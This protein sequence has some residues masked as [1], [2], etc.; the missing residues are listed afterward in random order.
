M[1]KKT[2]ICLL[3]TISIVSGI[4]ILVFRF[5]INSRIIHVVD[6]NGVPIQDAEV[7]AVTPSF[8]IGPNLSNEKGDAVLPYQILTG[9][10]PLG[11]EVRK[12]HFE[13]RYIS[14]PKEWP[15]KIILE[16]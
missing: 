14:I 3:I 13:N 10:E 7:Y 1:T 9:Q 15:C 16:K 5:N 8:N 11:I 4:G 6:E 12:L 2:V